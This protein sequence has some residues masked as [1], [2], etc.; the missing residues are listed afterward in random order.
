MHCINGGV[1]T[2]MT[3]SGF[4]IFHISWLKGHAG[5]RHSQV[6]KLEC[7][8]TKIAARNWICGC[9]NKQGM[10]ASWI[11]DRE[12][13][14]NWHLPHSSLT[15]SQ[16]ALGTHTRGRA[17]KFKKCNL[18]SGINL[19]LLTRLVIISRPIYGSRLG[20]P[21]CNKFP[22]PRIGKAMHGRG[23]HSKMINGH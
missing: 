12:K 5:W 19:I 20:A 2:W 21:H 11:V 10:I 3:F 13:W 8:A 7:V 9:G 15:P 23:A 22:V 16:C 17:N 18:W 6:R 4:S 14:I 1:S